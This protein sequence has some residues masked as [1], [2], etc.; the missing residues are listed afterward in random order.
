MAIRRLQSRIHEYGVNRKL[1][2]AGMMVFFFVIFDGILMYL[3]PIVITDAG[4]SESLMGLIIGSSSVAGMLLDVLLCE[5]LR[6]THFRR[7]FLL[8]FVLAAAFPVFLFGGKTAAIYLAA[9]AAWGFY[10]DFFNIGTID[11]VERTG[12]PQ[13]Q[14]SDFGVLSFFQGTG[15]LLAPFLGSLLLLW[16]HPG[17]RMFLAIAAPVAVSFI[18]YLIIASG[19][20]P[21]RDEYG[22]VSRKSPLHFFAE[23][24]LWKKVWSVLFP[25]LSL[26]L[27]LNLV[28]AAIWTFGPIFSESIGKAHGFSG[29][30]FMT[31]YALPPL[32]VGWIVGGIARRFGDERTAQWVIAIGSA[33]LIL[34][35]FVSSPVVSVALIFAVS[36]FFSIGWPAI[37][38]VYTEY[39]EKNV[40]RR[41]ETETLQDLFTNFGDVGGPIAAGYM[42]Q[43]LGFAHSFVALGV[44]GL[45]TAIVLSMISPRAAAAVN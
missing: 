21:E 38:A 16:L 37:S 45:L 1:F 43:Y 31:A 7:I 13:E 23:M 14:V 9:M 26:T 8:M 25:I 27:L 29:G 41:K 6:V 22:G 40:P 12:A 10:Y 15:Y 11:F 5:Y 18:F 33:V 44:L 4:I 3:A 19:S 17:P 20:V 28:D 39:I 30:V 36:F 34:I 32:V 35:G 24:G 42:A 2:F